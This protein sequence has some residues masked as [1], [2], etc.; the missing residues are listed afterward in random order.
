MLPLARPV[1]SGQD[2]P[3]LWGVAG[4][5]RSVCEL[6]GISDKFAAWYPFHALRL[7]PATPHSRDPSECKLAQTAWQCSSALSPSAVEREN[8][9]QMIGTREIIGNQGTKKW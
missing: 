1:T 3:R 7:G 5:S 9:R 6:R 4:P 2:G 8:P